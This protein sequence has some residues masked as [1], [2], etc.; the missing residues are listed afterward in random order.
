MQR[1]TKK[2]V[3]F[4]VTGITVAGKKFRLEFDDKFHAMNINL[5]RGKVYQV[6]NGKRSL[7]K[8]VTN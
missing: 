4:L 7:L 6:N 5:Y 8:T 2:G 3:S 1:I